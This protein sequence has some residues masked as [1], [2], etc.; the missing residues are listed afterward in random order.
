MKQI[1]LWNPNRGIAIPPEA[2]SARDIAQYARQLTKREV[3]QIVGAMDAGN[4]EMGALFLWQKAM[5]GLK[6]QIGSLGM[7]FVGELLD[8]TRYI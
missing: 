8:S 7:D 5:T 1:M 4:Y 6:G 3:T 2:T